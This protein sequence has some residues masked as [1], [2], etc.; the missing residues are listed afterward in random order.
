MVTLEFIV[1]GFPVFSAPI[2]Y[3]KRQIKQKE[4]K[5]PDQF[6]VNQVIRPTRQQIQHCRRGW[7][8]VYI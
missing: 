2:V 6:H 4:N 8:S 7:F 5:D 1:T 3:D